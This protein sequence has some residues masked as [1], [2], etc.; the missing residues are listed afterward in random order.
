[1]GVRTEDRMEEGMAPSGAGIGTRATP[2]TYAAPGMI[3]RGTFLALAVSVVSAGPAV[4]AIDKDEY[5]DRADSLCAR[6]EPKERELLH[7]VANA[8]NDGAVAFGRAQIRLGDFIKKA[9]NRLRDLPDPDRDRFLANRYIKGLK[10]AGRLR[11]EAGKAAL[12]GN[13]HLANER[14]DD[15]D[16]SIRK[17]VRSA[18]EF[19]YQRCGR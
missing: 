12:A 1:M 2:V 9:A 4:A 19:G 8:E 18:H 11:V 5:I 7:D 17:A 16:V 3:S 6:L 10:K 13:R 14:A 15:A